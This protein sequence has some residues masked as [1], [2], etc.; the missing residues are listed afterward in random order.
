M[1]FGVPFLGGVLTEDGIVVVA[2]VGDALTGVVY[3]AGALQAGSLLIVRSALTEI[4]ATMILPG[5]ITIGGVAFWRD[6]NISS[7][8]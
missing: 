4:P 7:S 2:L 6:P 3:L 8:S 1:R 5:S